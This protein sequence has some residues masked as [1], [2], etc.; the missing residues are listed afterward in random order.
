M[1][2]EAPATSHTAAPERRRHPKWF[3]RG[4]VY[5]VYVR[6][7]AD[8][9]GD[10]VGD[11]LGIRDR[12]EHISS[13]GVDAVW[14]TPCY[15]SPQFDHGY[16]V[17]DYLDIDERFG[18]MAAFDEMIGAARRHGVRVMLDIVPNHS[19]YEHPRFRAAVAAGRGSAERAWYYF[20]DG[21]GPSGDEPPNNWRA[22]FGG[23]AWTR[24]AEPDGSP[25]QWYLHTFTPWQ[26][27]FDWAN[28]EVVAYFDEVLRFWFDRGV[29][30]FRADAVSHLGKAPTLPDD[31]TFVQGTL[32]TVAMARNPFANHWPSQH[33]VW[34]HWRSV[35]DR[36]EADHPGRELVMVAEAYAPRRPD[37]VLGYVM[38]DE[39]HQCFAFDLTLSPWNASTM[40][41]AIEPTES[42][43]T[44]AGVWP[45]WVLE[46]HDVQRVVTRYGRADAT[47]ASSWTGSNLVSSE[48]PVDVV[49]GRRRA[50]AAAL[51]LLGLPGS[52]YLYQGQEL[53]LRE[54]IELPIAVR[55]DPML[56]HTGGRQL[57]RDG[58]RVPLPWTIDPRAA[59]GFSLAAQAAS[60]WLPQ[61]PDWGESTVEAAEAD[62]DSLLWLYRRAI[63]ARRE[64]DGFDAPGMRWHAVA[65]DALVFSR[66]AALVAVNLG[67][68]PLDL[69]DDLVEHRRVALASEPGHDDPRVVPPDSALWLAVTR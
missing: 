39:F 43:V 14:L 1:A 52:V 58:C 32:D 38:P 59:H 64:I 3:D 37:L 12:M 55:Q 56:R 68:A 10:G 5:Q 63:T 13:L 35:V 62:P 48:A 57:G 6:S 69:P 8:A 21:H 18:G 22:M 4:V 9:D 16:D 44:A 19:S 30:G 45:T 49:A 20:R 54:V 42:L 66:G 29:D 15:P 65:D 53:G 47:S 33:A 50:R 28:P 41:G 34:R 23:P 11:L 40:R 24:V 17:A 31:T 7:F 25:G 51:L 61:P 2:R 67:A 36:Y 46:N 27:D 26:P 60:P